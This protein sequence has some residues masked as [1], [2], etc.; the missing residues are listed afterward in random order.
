MRCVHELEVKM[1]NK[2]NIGIFGG[3]LRQVYMTKELLK[4]GH[5]LI[6]YNLHEKVKD[7][8]CIQAQNLN[9]LFKLSN[10][11]IG[12]IPMSRDDISI[13]SSKSL[14]DMTIAHVAYLLNKEHILFAGNIPSPITDICENK[15]I[16]FYDLMKNE[17]LTIL[18]AIATAEGTLM[19]AIRNSNKN[20]HR[21]SCLI[22]GYGRCGKVLARKLKALDANV[23]VTARSRDTLAYANA[24]G[25]YT[26]P[27][28]NIEVIL[29]SFDFIFNTIPALVLDKKCLDLVN[30]DVLIIDIASAPGGVDYDY[31]KKLGL[32]ARLCLG[33]PGK[34]AAESS[35]SL[36]VSEILMLM[37]EVIK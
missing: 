25:N 4:G 20:L 7:K 26:I 35:A 33:L 28:N 9:D 10:L 36:L 32:N 29:S 2:Y 30:N 13:F 14:S 16:P 1:K 18:N 23:T 21:S 27:L 12:P 3:D 19:E 37:K 24:F 22:L 11:V 6:T 5:N 8:N 15:N 31:A 34:V 17:K